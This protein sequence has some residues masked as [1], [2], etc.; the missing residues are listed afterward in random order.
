MSLDTGLVSAIIYQGC[1]R[2]REETVSPPMKPVN[3]SHPPKHCFYVL[4][5]YKSRLGDLLDLEEKTKPKPLY[6]VFFTSLDKYRSLVS[7]NM[8]EKWG[9]SNG[10]VHHSVL[11][12]SGRLFRFS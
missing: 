5:L 7:K 1:G 11:E 10:D 8:Q 4:F 12:S 2:D 9:V 6:A 3:S